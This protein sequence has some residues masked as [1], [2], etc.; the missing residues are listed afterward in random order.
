[1]NVLLISCLLEISFVAELSVTIV[2]STESVAVT[3]EATAQAPVLNKSEDLLCPN[4]PDRGHIRLQTN[5]AP[6]LSDMSYYTN[7]QQWVD[8]Y[9]I[10]VGK[11][12]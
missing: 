3:H 5:C 8:T 4:A 6:E 12:A 2:E 9:S 11:S 1:M 10:G 7:I